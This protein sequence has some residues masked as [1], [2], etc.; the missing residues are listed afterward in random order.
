[1]STDLSSR[2]SP[3]SPPLRPWLLFHSTLLNSC[4]VPA[5]RQRE[6]QQFL[7]ITKPVSTFLHRILILFL[8]LQGIQWSA[9][10]PTGASERRTPST[11][12]PR[13]RVLFRQTPHKYSAHTVPLPD[14]LHILSA[15]PNPVNLRR[16]SLHHIHSRHLRSRNIHN[17]LYIRSL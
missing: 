10:L 3:S 6:F 7:A 1:M 5:P 16:Y 17:N 12:N 13:G 8:H 4:V 11:R 15:T 2:S 14:S 9:N